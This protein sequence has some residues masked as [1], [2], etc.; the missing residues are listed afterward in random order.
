MDF[1]PAFSKLLNHVLGTPRCGKQHTIKLDITD[2]YVNILTCSQHIQV[3]AQKSDSEQSR[4]F[5]TPIA[6]W[7]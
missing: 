7:A 3:S 1:L 6:L 4:N 5:C 2:R